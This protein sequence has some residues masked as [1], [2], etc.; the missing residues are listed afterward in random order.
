MDPE[1]ALAYKKAVN[2]DLTVLYEYYVNMDQNL[3]CG[4]MNGADII[5]QLKENYQAEDG[6]SREQEDKDI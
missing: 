2:S 1:L 4:D 3:V 6:L 5:T